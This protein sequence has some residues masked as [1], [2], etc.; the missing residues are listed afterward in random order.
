MAPEDRRIA[1]IE[2]ALPLLRQHG[3]NVTTRQIAEAAGVAEGTIFRAFPN[4]D[5]LVDA[6]I[7][8][9]F[10]PLPYL[11]GLAGID[12]ELPLHD[13][14]VAMVE[15]FQR[16]LRGIIELMMAT[17]TDPPPSQDEANGKLKAR[18]KQLEKDNEQIDRAVLA[19]L[20]PDAGRLRYPPEQV[21][22]VLRML[23]FSASHP[24]ISA[25]HGRPADGRPLTPE[26]IADVVLNGVLED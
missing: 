25:A 23:T 7:A 12:T 1:L 24:M 4:K 3:R 20:E 16:R 21:A 13:R 22:H 18:R 17:R 14:V 6:A 8:S 19:L 2:A 5:A 10:D 9:A 15:L 11:A 26:Q